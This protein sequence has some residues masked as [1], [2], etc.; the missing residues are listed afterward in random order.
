MQCYITK[1]NFKTLDVKTRQRQ[2][3]VTTLVT[4]T[5]LQMVIYTQ[6]VRVINCDGHNHI[7]TYSVV[8][9]GV[10]VCAVML[11][12]IIH[13]WIRWAGNLGRSTTACKQP[14]TLASSVCYICIFSLWDLNY[15]IAANQQLLNKLT[16]PY[17]W[18]SMYL[19]VRWVLSGFCWNP[20]NISYNHVWIIWYGAFSLQSVYLKIWFMSNIVG[21]VQSVLCVTAEILSG[22][23][24]NTRLH[25]SAVK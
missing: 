4:L 21:A 20:D 10:C 3:L 1:I 8:M 17:S 22:R 24:H 12:V 19:W 2:D 14:N 7:L 23:E 16:H 15:E 25:T 5:Y 18:N 9:Y 6:G 11:Y 13:L